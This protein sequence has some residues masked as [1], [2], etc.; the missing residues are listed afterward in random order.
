MTI[1]QLEY[2]LAVAA[3][4]SFATAAE[5]CFVTAP[6]LSMQIGALEAELGATL[7]DR[8]KKPIAPTEAGAIFIEQARLAVNQ[9]HKA[10]EAVSELRGELSGVLRIGV[11]PTINPY[12][13]PLFIPRFTRKCPDIRLR[14]YDMYTA[15]MVDALATDG[16]DIGVLSGGRSEVKINERDL[17]DD[18]LYMYVSSDNKLYGRAK[19]EIRDID[20]RELLILSE[21]N[22]LR[23]QTL[24]LC[25]ARAASDPPFD[26]VR[27]SLENL[28]LTVDRTGGT[29]VIPAMAV[30]TIP[31][32]RRSQ[33]IPF[34]T[35]RALRKITMAVSPNFVREALV[36][37]VRR[38]ILEVASEE[39][40][41]AEFLVGD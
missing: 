38:T 41:M 4:G 15:D 20:V 5:H 23:N 35:E 14:I 26:F 6:A 9:F 25:E 37:I 18:R 10:R 22:C 8:N 30:H 31:K 40:A 33:I 12:L 36:D 7:L 21:G 2:F 32:E 19:I 17:F 1:V 29:T 34:S 11:I 16:I 27:S 24:E 28:M 13:M 39:F 3:H